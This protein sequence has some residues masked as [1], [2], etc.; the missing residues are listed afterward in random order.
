MGQGRSLPDTFDFLL[1]GIRH[2]ITICCQLLGQNCC[3]LLSAVVATRL[4]L[5]NYM[6]RSFGSLCN[7]A[8]TLCSMTS[9]IS[10]RGKWTLKLF[11]LVSHAT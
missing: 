5:V 11:L 9:R 1:H 6:S 4:L 3:E 10:Q 2:Q 8:G 7:H